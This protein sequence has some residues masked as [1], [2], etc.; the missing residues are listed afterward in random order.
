VTNTIA[1]VESKT[2][3]SAIPFYGLFPNEPIPPEKAAGSVTV[4][5]VVEL[6]DSKALTLLDAIGDNAKK[7]DSVL[8]VMHGT[9][10]GLW[11]E[12]GSEGKGKSLRRVR[13]QL[14]ALNVIRRHAE[15]AHDD[16]EAAKRLLIDAAGWKKL[17]AQIDRVQKLELDRVD[18]RACN[19]GQNSIVMNALQIFFN[20]N[21][22]CAPAIYDSFGPIPFAEVTRNP[23]TWAE[24]QLAHRDATIEGTSP[25]RFALHYKIVGNTQ[26]MLDVLADSEQA[27]QDWAKRHLPAGNYSTGPLFYHAFTNLQ[28]LIFAGD[29]GFR[30]QLKEAYKG[31]A[32]P[33]KVDLDAPLPIP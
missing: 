33:R 12:I 21:T 2:H 13:L 30:D 3:P 9:D 19:T 24:W 1:F 17:K 22:L 7:G 18:L 20:C 32:D 26:V 28:T 4:T 15:G 10:T 27:V 11:A 29:P 31:M 5:K 25:N 6:K 14:N 16:A 23:K 8:I